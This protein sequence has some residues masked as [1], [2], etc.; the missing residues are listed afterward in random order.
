ML[1][2]TATRHYF[3]AVL[4]F[5][6]AWQHFLLGGK[7]ELMLKLQLPANRSWQ[8]KADMIF[9]ACILKH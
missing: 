1:F 6:R 7:C 5:S 4:S 3:L 9:A 8:N 2:W